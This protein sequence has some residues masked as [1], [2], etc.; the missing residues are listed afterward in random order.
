MLGQ[1]TIIKI[2][3][4]LKSGKALN[5]ENC[6]RDNIVLFAYKKDTLL[7]EPLPILKN[8]HC[9]LCSQCGQIIIRR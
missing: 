5:C 8:G 2:P 3:A 6:K 9:E 4:H 1:G 7:G